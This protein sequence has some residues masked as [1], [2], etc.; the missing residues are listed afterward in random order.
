MTKT[1]SLSIFFPMFNEAD[2]IAETITRTVSVAEASPYLHDYE[3]IAVNDGSH[4]NSAEIVHALAQTNPRVRLINHP[5]NKGYGEALKT[6]LGAARM[7]YVFF[8]DADLQFDIKELQNLLVHLHEHAAV[9]GY[10]APR[11]DPLMRLLNAW[12]WN[13]LNRVLFGLNVR[14]IDCAFKLF[15]REHIQNIELR[16]SGAMISAEMLIRLLRNNVRVKQVPVSHLPRIAGSATGASLRVIARAF[17]E[18]VQLYRGDLGNVSQKEALRFMGVGVINTTIDIVLY[19]ALTRS[20]IFFTAYLT[21][22]K[23]LSFFAGTVSSLYLNRTWTFKVEERLTPGEILRFYTTAAI[24]MSVNVL[25]MH[26]FLG[27]GVYDLYALVLTT[28]VTLGVNFALS[29]FW[30]FKKQLPSTGVAHPYANA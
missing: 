18:M 24:S 22:A 11:R 10:R 1:I 3:I 30:V 15:K 12:G 6:G 20:F 23:F 25:M 19:F 27:M 29:K 8:T 28:V 7:D 14:D 9:I 26:I 13:L 5:Y 21:I 17:Q 16:S 4:D 2:N